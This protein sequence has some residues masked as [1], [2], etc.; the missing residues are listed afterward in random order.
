LRVY[1]YI[2]R[3][4]YGFAPNPFHNMCTLATCKPPI[5]R[6]ARI[7]DWII[8]TGA[9]SNSLAGRLIFAMQVSEALTF[10]D[11][12]SDPR[13]NIKKPVLNGSLKLLYGDNIYH[14]DSS[15]RWLQADSHHSRPNGRRHLPNLTR[16]TR[17]NRVLLANRFVY[18]GRDSVAIPGRFRS[19][20]C[21][22][23]QGQKKIEG[24]GVAP[25]LRWVEAQGQGVV[26]FPLEYDNHPKPYDVFLC[27]NSQ[28][29]P[30]VRRLYRQL[31]KHGVSPWF[32][33]EHIRPGTSW[34]RELENA[35]PTI[36]S[37]AVVVGPNGQ[38][39]WQSQEIDAFLRE[40]V[41]RG[42]P[43]IPVL[44]KTAPAEPQL[45]IFL[46]GL[47]WVDFRQAR[48]NPWRQLLWGITDSR[49]AGRA[50]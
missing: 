33:E 15:G 50:S 1:S 46:R 32:D 40:F 48:P 38:G 7:G 36:R 4:D 24:P 41:S 43:V 44:L 9:S 5:R 12:W 11:Y 3:Y 18:F 16:D 2:V 34:Q 10:N 42:C 8:G 30:S 28:D 14:R 26:G 20:F 22:N 31:I 35:I 19:R 49:P 17:A 45:P 23:G 47:S 25:F 37:A 21:M 27:H 13:F 29:K 39:P 6:G